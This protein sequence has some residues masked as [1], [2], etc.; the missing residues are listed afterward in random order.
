MANT[1]TTHGPTPPQSATETSSD[2]TFVVSDREGLQRDSKRSLAQLAAIIVFSAAGAVIGSFMTNNRP[3]LAALAGGILGMIVGTFVSGFVLMLLPTPIKTMTLRQIRS[4]YR[5][6]RS[7]LI[8]ATI[9]LALFMLTLPLI[10]SQFGDDESTFACA[11][12]VL[13]FG[14]T[15]V[16]F[17]YTKMLAYRLRKWR[18]PACGEPFGKQWTSCSNCGLS[19]NPDRETAI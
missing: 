9:V 19:I 8:I 12:C 1:D 11:M 7:R 4:K 3:D 2:E 17:V 13:W 5:Q 14:A 18:C 10:I 16:L 15:P 6:L